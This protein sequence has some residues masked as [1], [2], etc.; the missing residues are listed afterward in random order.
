MS[1][2]SVSGSIR[3]SGAG[4]GRWLFVSPGRSRARSRS[5]ARSFGRR[6][7]QNVA[8]AVLDRR[9]DDRA[10]VLVHEIDSE[11]HA[12]ARRTRTQTS[13]PAVVPTATPTST[14][15][16]VATPTPRSTPVESTPPRIAAAPT[17]TP[18]P[19]LAPTRHSVPDPYRPLLRSRHR[20]RKN[21]KSV[22]LNQCVPRI[23]RKQLEPR[24]RP[25]RRQQ[26][27]SDKTKWPSGR[28]VENLYQSR[29]R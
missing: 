21:P 5:G 26:H 29:S 16:A 6:R 4:N 24:P 7:R 17:A 27:R 18:T 1:T 8:H 13:E 25:L 19:T 2:L 20:R 14:P 9:R 11:H 23:W 10:W 28:S 22:A 15:V 3:H 12:G